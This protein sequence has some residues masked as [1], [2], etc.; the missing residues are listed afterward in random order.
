MCSDHLK[1]VLLA[2]VSGFCSGCATV[3]LFAFLSPTD[4]DYCGVPFI[5]AMAVSL[6][7]SRQQGWLN[8]TPSLPRYS[9]AGVLTFSTYPL[10]RWVLPIVEA[11][12]L[13]PNHSRHAF[14][15]WTDSGDLKQMATFLIMCT[16]ISSSALWIASGRCSMKAF[17]LLMI[18]AIMSGWIA[19]VLTLLLADCGY[20]IR[21]NSED[22]TFV[23]LLVILGETILGAVSAEWIASASK[24]RGTYIQK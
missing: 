20:S 7:V 9:A 18:G 15:F 22:W 24:N 10:I 5:L 6:F 23:S 3:L 12:P 21:I 8:F 19:L 11:I 2:A 16:I 1:T 4:L 14:S 17:I 13:S